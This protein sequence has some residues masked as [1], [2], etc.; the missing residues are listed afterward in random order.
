[1][2]LTSVHEIGHLPGLP[3]NP[4]GSSVMFYLELDDAVL[5]DAADLD[6]RWRIARMNLKT[7]VAWLL[8]RLHPMFFGTAPSLSRLGRSI[9]PSR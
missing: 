9:L 2:F 6:A 7:A 4:S 1:M 3:H 5:L 8:R